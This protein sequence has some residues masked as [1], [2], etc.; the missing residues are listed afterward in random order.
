MFKNALVYRIEDWAQPTLTEIES[1]LAGAPFIEC[2]A[3]QPESS[4]FVPPRGDKHASLAESVGGQIVFKLCTETKAVPG[5]VVKQ[6]LAAQL[7]KIEQDTGRRPT[8]KAAKELKEAVVHALLPR[9]FPKR[10]ETLVW[11]D[12]K[13]QRVWVGAG[14]TKKADALV[15]KLI[16]LL[17]G[18]LKLGL[19][20]TELAPATAMA[21]WLAEKEAPAGFSIDR[22]CELKQPDAE[23]AS[24]RYARHTLDIDEVGEHIKQGKLPTQLAL[25]WESRVSFV[26]TE[27]LTLK[28]IELLDVVLEGAGVDAANSGTGR[29]DGKDDAGF[30]ADVAIATGEL[31]QMLPALVAALGGVHERQA[32]AA[33]GGVAVATPPAASS[34]KSAAPW[35]VQP[36]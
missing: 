36:A 11:L 18:G 4:G 8:G 17:G 27:A 25:T 32:A 29:S 30:D 10:S 33:A 19:L 24:V 15:T 13:A 23:K 9:A 2:G 35:D 12:P 22:E 21:M 16:E 28:K 6:Q 20:Q 34:G 5:G 1:R 14:S 7:D 26:L 3:T 31:R